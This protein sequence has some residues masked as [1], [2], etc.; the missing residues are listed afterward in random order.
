MGAWN[1]WKLLFD[2]LTRR[3]VPRG[4]PVDFA[5]ET[6]VK[7]NLYCPMCY[8]ETFLQPNE[9]MANPIYEKFLEQAEGTAETAMLIG[10]GEPLLDA[11]IF[12]RITQCRN[13]HITALIS[14]NGTLL[15]EEAANKLL[16]TGVDHITLSFDGTTKE[17]F[18]LYRKGAN[19]EKV[20]DNF[21]RLARLKQ[22]RRARTFLTAQMILMEKNRHQAKE[23]ISFWKAVPGID[24][25]RV[26]ADESDLLEHKKHLPS[27][28]K[29]PC[30]YLWRGPMLI[31]YDGDVHPCC[32]SYALGGQPVGNLRQQ[33][34]AEIWNNQ[35]MQRM[36]ELHVAGRASEID[37]CRNC[38]VAIP[39][40]ALVVGSLLFHGN[41][42]RKVIPLF[43]RL[44]YVTKSAVKWLKP[45]EH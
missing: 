10:L 20:R 34:L 19:F 4:R 40:P 3:T 28:W 33:T 7:C 44:S 15:T 11:K 18:E 1:R 2:Y 30:H 38:C 13:R 37:I 45:P 42:V 41:T 43:E 32:Q 6:T 8:R 12:D 29:S 35:Q 9:D 14:T 26:K 23:F 31:R 25:V 16:D 39:H 22:E 24:Q 36:R 27:D 17:A 21:I 5:V